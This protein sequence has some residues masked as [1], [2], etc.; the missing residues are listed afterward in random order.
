M[1]FRLAEKALRDYRALPSSLQARVD[2]QLGFLC[3]TPFGIADE[4]AGLVQN[5]SMNLDLCSTPFGIAEER[6]L[7]IGPASPQLCRIRLL[8]RRGFIH[9][10]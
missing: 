3:S 7:D 4:F 1:R 6:S 8:V 9:E 5:G 2:K 10:N